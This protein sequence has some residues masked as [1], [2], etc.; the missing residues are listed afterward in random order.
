MYVY[1]ATQAAE[2]I[3]CSVAQLRRLIRAG[4]IS[5]VDICCSERQAKPRYRISEKSLSEFM[6]LHHSGHSDAMS[7]PP[8]SD[9]APKRHRRLDANVPK[10]F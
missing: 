4:R 9:A 10:V 2:R 6:N 8:R 5:A 1:T 3:G 7:A